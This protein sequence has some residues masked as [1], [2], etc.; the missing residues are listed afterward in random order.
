MNAA[1]DRQASAA[2]ERR[3]GQRDR[4]SPPLVSA[5]LPSRLALPAMHA[6]ILSL[7]LRFNPDVILAV[8][9]ERPRHPELDHGAA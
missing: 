6:E 7:R 9:N 2:R 5:P 1:S 4:C 8:A 3:V